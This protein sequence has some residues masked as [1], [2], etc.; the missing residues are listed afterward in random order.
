MVSEDQDRAAPVF[1]VQFGTLADW[2]A[3]SPERDP[4]HVACSERGTAPDKLSF[5]GE[6]RLLTDRF[7]VQKEFPDDLLRDLSTQLA[8][9]LNVP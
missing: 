8:A 3:A 1:D 6:S 7:R 2:I 4:L 5:A 9:R